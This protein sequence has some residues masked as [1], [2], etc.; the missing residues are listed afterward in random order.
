MA[1]TH[2]SGSIHALSE[3]LDSIGIKNYIESSVELVYTHCMFEHG[4]DT[5]SGLDC[6]RN[7]R[8]EYR[9]SESDAD[10]FEAIRRYVNIARLHLPA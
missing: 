7:F 1:L 4:R 2:P 9:A 8:R 6:F 5:L 3:I 10:D